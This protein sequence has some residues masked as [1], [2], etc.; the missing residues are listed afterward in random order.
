MSFMSGNVFLD[1]NVL[2]YANDAAEPDKQQIARKLLTDVLHAEN[3]VISVQVLSEFWVT[4][5]RKI[6]QPLP[7]STALREAELFTL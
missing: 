2:V 5:K 6:R 7:L 3:G 4:V 1:T